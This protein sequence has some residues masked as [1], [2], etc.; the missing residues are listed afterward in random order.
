MSTK[1]RD[2]GRL[3]KEIRY[4]Q[5]PCV[6]VCSL[7]LPVMVQINI[8]TSSPD[9]RDMVLASHLED[10]KNTNCL[11]KEKTPSLGKRCQIS[12]LKRSVLQCSTLDSVTSHKA[13]L[14]LDS[15]QLRGL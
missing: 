2:K 6:C 10:M 14:I 12:F 13:K 7:S 4:F 8:C 1:Q 11:C 3:K 9:N 5:Q 15:E